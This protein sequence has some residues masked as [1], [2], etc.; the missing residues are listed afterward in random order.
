MSTWI[1][2]TFM[3]G[4][5]SKGMFFNEVDLPSP[6]P[7]RD[8]IFTSALGSP[9]PFGRQLDG[10]GGGISSLSKVV[11]VTASDRPDADLEYTFGQVAVDEAVVDYS[12]N[13]GNLSSAVVPFALLAGIY[14][15]D[16]D[17][18]ASVVVHN[19][20]TDKLIAIKLQVTDGVAA[21]NGE[22]V[23]PG[24]ATTGS[25][26]ELQYLSPGGSKTG[27][28]LP[29]GNPIDTIDLGDRT[30]E[31]SLIDAA[32]P[33]VFV[34]AADLGL[35]GSEMPQDLDADPAT[36]A[37]LDR[38]RRAGA[39][40]MG[41]SAT[42]K[43]ASLAVPKVAIV[44]PPADTTLLDGTHVPAAD[45]DIVARTVSMEL[46]HRAIPG[47]AALCAA[48]AANI[49]G[50]VVERHSTSNGRDL[51]IATPSGVVTSAADV[52]VEDG[53]T[54]VVGAS[55]FRTARALMRGQ[56]EVLP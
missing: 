16:R 15:V 10:M 26:I 7:E 19:T 1:D 52:T 44:A 20:N 39:V 36:M 2:A 9:D 45:S 5:T 6:G 49:P 3:R 32:N 27:A 24:V 13:C 30:I 56:I 23:L 25:P 38:I 37:L 40:A 51:R 18:P 50:T 55:L 21:T 47:T 31:A 12:G 8:H 35:K 33:M 17:G 48:T 41:M 29:T 43:D 34:A 4:G 11:S 46:V 14:K 42:P 22:F 53:V 54:T 28:L